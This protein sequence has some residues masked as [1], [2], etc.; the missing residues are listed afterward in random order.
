MFIKIFGFLS[1]V[2]FNLPE[3]SL[4]A[5]LFGLVGGYPTG[6]LLCDELFEAGEIDSNQAKR[7]MCFNFCGGCGFIITAVGSASFGNTK[8]GVML[9]LS[10]VISSLIIGFALS[11]KEKRIEKSTYSLTEYV[12]LGDA[13]TLAAPK[14][15]QSVIVITAYI[16][17]FSA[18]SNIF[19]MPEPVLPLLEITNGVCGGDFSLPLTAAFLSFGGICIHL[20]ISQSLRKIKM[21]YFE[22]L[23]FRLISSV[24]SYFVMKIMLRIFPL[25]VP[26][27][28]NSTTP[29]KLTSVNITLSVLLIIGCFV[30]VL[31]LN[32]RKKA[33]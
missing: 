11:F 21:S 5:L 13:L 30:S 12:P 10:N 32:S 9:F 1:R 7:M 22:F 3:S 26:V 19:K 14:A 8:I 28:A 31:D 24:L 17:L 15:S 25:E 23:L 18:L 16:V 29:V 20:Q 27:F 2:L 33:V 6:A 4:S